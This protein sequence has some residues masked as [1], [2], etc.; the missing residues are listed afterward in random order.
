M[1][2]TGFYDLSQFEPR[3]TSTEQW[4]AASH[5]VLSHEVPTI[6]FCEP[7]LRIRLQTHGETCVRRPSPPDFRDLPRVE[8]NL[9]ASK[10][11]WDPQKDTP[12][13]FCLMRHRVCWMQE[14][15]VQVGNDEQVLTWVDIGIPHGEGD[16]LLA[17]LARPPALGKIRL[18]EISYV[19]KHARVSAEAYYARHWWPVGGGLWSARAPEIHWLAGE[20]TREWWT[21]LSAGFVATDE[22]LLGRIV[23]RH[24]ERFERY[25]GDHPTLIRNWCGVRGSHRL[26]VEMAM[27]A[28]ED[29]DAPAAQARLEAAASGLKTGAV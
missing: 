25:Y 28:L 16:S 6:L 20:M 9:A 19:P 7:A 29:G 26:I 11:A 8:A 10:W 4:I 24:P 12:R 5:W 21:A 27:R 1:M 15:A 22:M 2:V 18:C 17:V 14:A 3:R 13:Y 23:L